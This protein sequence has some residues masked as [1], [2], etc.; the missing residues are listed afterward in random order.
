MSKYKLLKEK[1][2]CNVYLLTM[3]ATRIVGLGSYAQW[4]KS[5]T[6]IIGITNQ[7]MFACSLLLHMWYHCQPRILW[8]ERSQ[9]LV[10]NPLLLY[11]LVNL[12][13]HR[14]LTTHSYT[15]DQCISPPEFEKLLFATDSD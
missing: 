4:F 15:L 2:N 14:P 9:A 8:L 1:N 6:N 11:C 12:V 3:R 5:D 10:E 13:L 7:F